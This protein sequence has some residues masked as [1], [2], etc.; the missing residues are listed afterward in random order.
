M[1]VCQEFLQKVTFNH[2]DCFEKKCSIEKEKL[3][4]GKLVSE[5]IKE[6][7]SNILYSAFF[8]NFKSVQ[9]EKE[10][11]CDI[12]YDNSE[13]LVSEL[14]T[15][16][17]NSINYYLDTFVFLGF[18][19][20]VDNVDDV[21]SSPVSPDSPSNINK[22]L[23]GYQSIDKKVVFWNDLNVS[24]EFIQNLTYTNLPATFKKLMKSENFD[25]NEKV[26]FAKVLFW[27][28]RKGIVDCIIQSHNIEW[29]T[30]C[31]AVSSGSKKLTSDYDI[32]VYG[33]C[34]SKLPIDF[35]NKV[36][37][38]FS[39][40]SQKVFDTN[41]YSSS[42][43]DMV[44][45]EKKEWYYSESCGVYNFWY[46]K[47]TLLMSSNQH[48][49]AAIKLCENMYFEN[50]LQEIMI[51]D[52]KDSSGLSSKEKVTL[53][54][55][56][57]NIADTF[58]NAKKS[59]NKS[60][61]VQP[62]LLSKYAQVSEDQTEFS[63]VISIINY[64][65]SETYYTRGAFLDV[66][67]NQQMCKGTDKHID[68]ETLIDSFL[69]NLADFC[70]YHGKEKYKDRSLNAAQHLDSIKK[71]NHYQNVEKMFH[72]KE[73]EN[74]IRYGIKY[75]ITILNIGRIKNV[76]NN[77]ERIPF[78]LDEEKRRMSRG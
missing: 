32:T 51:R 71:T 5:G 14:H 40:T 48:V 37:Q 60:L 67:V 36:K 27:F 11:A 41:V 23:T 15:H 74:L 52:K 58:K 76:K 38:I 77:I 24:W 70:T 34:S 1:D 43:I 47:S 7:I 35:E 49:W 29:K 78:M 16:A 2:C 8:K 12:F 17:I 55:E 26:E 46:L 73:Y 28:F 62:T 22:K 6:K 72:N 10:K 30:R 4:E 66:V 59:K 56:I 44:E 50:V 25:N 9:N 63:D 42:F 45:P 31:I 39:E 57:I 13:N 18:I 53:L 75:V 33:L 20:F 19:K 65:G 64:L 69:E 21:S 54:I 3:Y 61:P 68:P